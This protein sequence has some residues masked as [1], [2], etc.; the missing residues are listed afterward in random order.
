MAVIRV[1]SL[2]GLSVRGENGEPLAGAAAQPRRM[3]VLAILARTGERGTTREKLLAILWPDAD[4]DRGS[5]ALTHALYALRRDL[6]SD[7]AVV[8]TRELRL[9][10]AIVSSDVAEF[11]AAVARGDDE[12]AAAL[13]EGPFLD[14]FRLTD[15]DAFS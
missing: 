11:A 4:A 14:G 1:H 7:D 15:V 10:P 3:A 13:Y 2:G 8:G 6:G 5:R 9:N 12:H